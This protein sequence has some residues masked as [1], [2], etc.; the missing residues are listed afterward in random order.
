MIL[1]KDAVDSGAWLEI[2][3]RFIGNLF[4]EPFDLK[5]RIKVRGFDKINLHGLGETDHFKDWQRDF[6]ST[7]GYDG[8]V[9]KL[10]LDLV[11][12]E[13]TTIGSSYIR[14]SICL[15]DS[16]GYKF[17]ACSDSFITIGSPFAKESGLYRF[18]TI[19]FLPKIKKSGPYCFELP[20]FFD[21]IYISSAN[22]TIREI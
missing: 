1:L 18:M 20:E 4:T 19:D 9:W 13:K 14:H 8:N 3:D 21:D 2:S 10:D 22:G 15:Q 6:E 16:E 5:F 11:N 17:P 12:M 7:I